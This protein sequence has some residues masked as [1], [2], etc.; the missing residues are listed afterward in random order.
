MHKITFRNKTIQKLTSSFLIITILVPVVLFSI[1]VN[2][3]H[4][5]AQVSPPQC[6][7]MPC[8]SESTSWIAKIFAGTTATQTTIT[9]GISVKMWAQELL[10]EILRTFAR[11]LLAKMTEAT[12]NWINSGFHGAPLF[13]ERPESFFNDIAKFEI[14]DLINTIGYDSNRYPFGKAFAL[15]VIQSYKSKFESNAQYSLSKVINDPVLLNNYRNNFAVGGWN[16]FLLNT[17]YPQNNFIGSQILYSNELASRL[18]GNPVSNNIQKVQDTLQKGMGFLSPQTCPTNSNY[19]NF[20]NEFTKPSFKPKAKPPELPSCITNPTPD[21]PSN[22]N[23]CSAEAA[24]YQ[25][26][27]SAYL[28]ASNQEAVDYA[29]K[30]DCPGGLVNTTPGSVVASHIT[31][32]INSPFFQTELGAAMGNSLSAIFDALLNQFLSKG[33]N[34]L[35]SKKNTPP[36]ADDF[37]YFGQTLGSPSTSTGGGDTFDWTGPD[38]VIVLAD[39]KRDVQ[40]LID[41]A[42]KELKLIDNN[43]PNIPGAIQLFDQIIFPKTQE[44]DS[45]LPG[46]NYGWRDRVDAETQRAGRELQTKSFDPNPAKANAAND[47]LN[48]L[49]YATDSFKAWLNDKMSSELPSG[50]EFLNTVNSVKGINK[51]NSELNDRKN[52]I[53]QTLVDLLSIKTELD[54]ITTQ[55]AAGSLAEGLMVR[56]KQRLDGMIINLSTASTVS[57]AQATLDDAIVKLTNLNTLIAKCASERQTKGWSVPG[58]PTSTL[59]GNTEQA[60]FCSLPL[61]GGFSHKTFINPGAVTYPEIPLVNANNVYPPSGIVDTSISVALSCDAIYRTSITDYKKSNP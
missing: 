48:A 3:K 12:V 25:K 35:S 43:D 42:N 15:N 14:K 17:Q 56:L 4:V 2:P 8:A 53:N 49:T 6:V 33:L 59:G 7:P 23:Y 26:D 36:P 34:S 58:G 24:Q 40:N 11:R 19:N 39:L 61:A 47:A 50:N 57:E 16:G 20:V 54:T 37:S 60:L 41:N 45:C 46:P 55:P 22:P 32:A 21:G 13:L 52:A 5:N 30:Y 51:K 10:K 44:L 29:K 9:A 31:R 28:A 27:Y 1:S 18:A 38:Q